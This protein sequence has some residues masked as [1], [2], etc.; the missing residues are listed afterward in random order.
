MQRNILQYATK[1]RAIFFGGGLGIFEGTNPN[2][3]HL[4]YTFEHLPKNIP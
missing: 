2:I 1:H 4:P 3:T